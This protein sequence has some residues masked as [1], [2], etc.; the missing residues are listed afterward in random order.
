[1]HHYRQVFRNGLNE[2]NHGN[3]TPVPYFTLMGEMTKAWMYY[4]KQE[5]PGCL[6]SLCKHRIVCRMVNRGHTDFNTISA[7]KVTVSKIFDWYSSDFGDL[8]DFLNKYADTKINADAAVDYTEYNWS[9]Y[10]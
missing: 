6:Y 7:N 5:L 4:K 2:L 3:E 8:K 9:L 1:M 10:E